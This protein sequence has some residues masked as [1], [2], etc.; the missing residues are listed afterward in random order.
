[1]PLDSRYTQVGSNL[2]SVQVWPAIIQKRDRLCQKVLNDGHVGMLMESTHADHYLSQHCSHL[3]RMGRDLGFRHYAAGFPRGSVYA[4]RVSRQMLAYNEDGRMMKLR[5][6][7]FGSSGCSGE[8][9]EKSQLNLSQAAGVNQFSKHQL[10]EK[11]RI[12]PA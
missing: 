12:T 9:R 6:K 2:T 4:D 5:H 11:K 3:T 10:I 1:M 7:W 8:A